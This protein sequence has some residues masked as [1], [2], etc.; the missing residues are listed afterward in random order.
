MRTLNV[1][2][3][4][5][6]A[7]I[8]VNGVAREVNAPVPVD[9][10][11]SAQFTK[12]LFVEGSVTAE[13]IATHDSDVA[14]ASHTKHSWGKAVAIVLSLDAPSVTT[15]T[16]SAVYLDGSDV[17]LVRATV[18]DA[19]GVVVHTSTTN[20]TFA[21]TSG[22]VRMA[23]VG[24]GDPADHTPAHASWKPCYHGLARAILKTTVKATGSDDAR[25]LEALVNKEAG[26]GPLSSKIVTDGSKAAASFTVTAS[27]EGLKAGSLTVSLSTEEKDSVLS[28]AAASI[29]MADV[30]SD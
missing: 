3:N 4:A 15:G 28:V 8:L 25:A 1:Y 20:V 22:P 9:E 29:G 24:N 23:G 19:N 5:P 6:F 7:R 12:V 26:V 18:V 21:V 30:D 13:G 17:A 14:L 11:G 2:T 10:Y 16:G 27:A